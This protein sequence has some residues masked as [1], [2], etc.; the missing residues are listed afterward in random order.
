MTISS[1][2]SRACDPA[3]ASAIAVRRHFLGTN[4]RNRQGRGAK[5]IAI[6]SPRRHQQF[7]VPFRLRDSVQFV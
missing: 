6:L 4:Q 2:M 1:L 3:K 5:R 7:A